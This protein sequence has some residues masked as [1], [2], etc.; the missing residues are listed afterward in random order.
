MYYRDDGF[1]SA[2]STRKGKL[3]FTSPK[4]FQ[5]NKINMVL[6]NIRKTCK[7]KS[8]PMDIDQEYLLSI[9]P[10]DFTCPVSG[11]KMQWGKESGRDNSPSIDRIVPE[12]G[13]VKGNLVWVS[14][15]INRIKFNAS[16]E[17][18]QQIANYYG[19]FV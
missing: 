15:R 14:C 2:G 4:A 10:A 11:I 9:F 12:K 19:Q 13:Y 16:I 6:N 17:L 8:L 3:V 18:L 7:E 5:R 1:L